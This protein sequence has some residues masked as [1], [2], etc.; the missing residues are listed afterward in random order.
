MLIDYC[1]NVHIKFTYPHEYQ[2][3]SLTVY[4]TEFNRTTIYYRSL[5]Y[6]SY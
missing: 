1:S 3:N 4:N 2:A 5:R 6:G